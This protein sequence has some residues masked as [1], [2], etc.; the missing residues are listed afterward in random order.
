MQPESSNALCSLCRRPVNAE[1]GGFSLSARLCDQCK[2]MI[3]A[4]KP[5][6]SKAE[7]KLA[8]KEP[9]AALSTNSGVFE[10]SP[11]QPL[12]PVAE[13]ET[14]LFGQV[15][16]GFD[17]NSMSHV[18]ML[19]SNQAPK[20][21]GRVW[22]LVV[23][24]VLAAGGAV[25]YSQI[26]RIQGLLTRSDH[27]NTAPVT[28]NASAP[29]SINTKPAAQPASA[30]NGQSGQPASQ[31]GQTGT[32][33]ATHGNPSPQPAST[34]SGRDLF[35][36]QAAS[37]PNEPAA[38][39]FSEKLVRAG[40]PAYVIAA[41]IPRRGK[42]YRVRAGKFASQEEARKHGLEWQQR[43]RAA[44]VGIQLVACVFEQP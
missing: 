5:A 10:E 39:Q 13:T 7:S 1:E 42:W 41:E 26:D 30:S 24:L 35:S 40:V 23:F 44:G 29:A 36:L 6:E 4:I 33:V 25:A 37:F 8:S 21:R 14:P 27:K 20:S 28:V 43:A 32:A 31:P 16:S 19:V 12:S 15:G 3:D 17:W 38:R 11:L 22:L 34:Q 18:P 9:A 2:S